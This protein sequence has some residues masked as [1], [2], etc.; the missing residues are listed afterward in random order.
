MLGKTAD[1]ARKSKR[2]ERNLTRTSG[3]VRINRLDTTALIDYL[4]GDE[5]IAEYLEHNE[6]L[7]L[8]VPTVALHEVFASAGRLRGRDG[9]EEARDDLDWVKPLELSADGAAEAAL[10]RA[11]LQESENKIGS[12]DTSER[13][14][15]VRLS[16]SPE[17][18]S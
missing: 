6:P 2:R 16:D 10:V 8:F 5:A 3:N 9:V 15:I 1:S 4:H 7:P 14:K 17:N 11:E 18:R 12:M 13:S